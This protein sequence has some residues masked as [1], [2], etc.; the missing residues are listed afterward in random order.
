MIELRT[1]DKYN[2]PRR[3]IISNENDIRD[4]PN[5]II[6]KARV[7]FTVTGSRMLPTILKLNELLNKKLD[8]I[9]M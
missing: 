4:I 8:E 5:K 7:R 9:L 3:Y 6:S 2:E 1:Y